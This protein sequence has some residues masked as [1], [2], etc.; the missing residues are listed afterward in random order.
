M[1]ARPKIERGLRMEVY[2]NDMVVTDLNTGM[3]YEGEAIGYIDFNNGEIGIQWGDDLEAETDGVL[4]LYDC[5]IEM[6]YSNEE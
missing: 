5:K 3:K 2:R 4:D 6:V 1:H